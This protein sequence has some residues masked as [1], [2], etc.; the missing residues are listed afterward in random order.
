MT[1]EQHPTAAR[2]IR[3]LDARGEFAAP[4]RVRWAGGRISLGGEAAAGDLD[5]TGLWMIPGLV[6]AHLHAGWQAFDA[7]DRARFG[8]ERTGKLIA[9]ALRRTLA[10]GFTAVRDAGGLDAAQLAAIPPWERPRAQLAVQLI[11]RAV[12]DAAGGLE[13]A[14]EEALGA[15]ARWVK[16]VATAGVAAPAGVGLD[17]V[18]SAEEQREAVRRAAREGAGVMVHA[19]GGTA[20]DHAIEA[21]ALSIEHG[22]FLT[23][24]QAR[25]AAERGMTLVPTLRIYRLV[26]GMIDAGSL[27]AAFRAR[28][29]EA[30]AAHPRA[31]LR[32]RDAGLAIALGTDYGTV[33]QHGTGRLEFDALVGAG[34]SP[35]EALLAA[36]RS[37]AELL[38]R[39]ADVADS[40][41]GAIAEGALAD[42]VILRR[43]PREPGA[44]SDPES[45]VAVLLGG[46]W[47]DPAR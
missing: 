35:Q 20:I 9:A 2:G 40:P 31:V 21:G 44:L 36:T 26:Q 46:R 8:E 7:V 22:I 24:A 30:V 4:V 17:P 33:E 37:G 14:V 29:D 6:D 13:R 38:A 5:G 18:F 25:R 43:D 23:D 1:G 27:P 15:G 3:I 19:W 34:L 12:A 47:A 10:S 16:L 42:A 11:D 39:V 28:V 32:A 45:I 41:T